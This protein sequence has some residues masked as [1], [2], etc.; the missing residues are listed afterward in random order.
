MKVSRKEIHEDELIYSI[1]YFKEFINFRISNLLE[2]QNYQLNSIRDL[3]EENRKQ[4]E[5][6]ITKVTDNKI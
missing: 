3:Y 1:I 4:F 6:E 2:Y 5:K